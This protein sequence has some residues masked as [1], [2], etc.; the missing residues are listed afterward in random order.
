[1]ES[2]AADTACDQEGLENDTFDEFEEE[3]DIPRMAFFIVHGCLEQKQPRN[4]Y[5][6]KRRQYCAVEAQDLKQIEAGIQKEFT[7]RH[8]PNEVVLVEDIR[9]VTISGAG[10]NKN[11]KL[12]KDE[13]RVRLPLSTPLMLA[14]TFIKTGV[15]FA[16]TVRIVAEFH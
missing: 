7:G 12:P 16:T 10:S 3:K 14:E 13:D 8:A 1:M 2:V 9:N 4:S 15:R 11:Y 5:L 6:G